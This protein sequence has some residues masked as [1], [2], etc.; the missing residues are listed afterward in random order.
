MVLLPFHVFAAQAVQTFE[1]DNVSQPV[2]MLPDPSTNVISMQLT[3]R[4]GITLDPNGKEGLTSLLGDMMTSGA[5]DYD[6]AALTQIMKDH[7][8]SLSINSRRD[9]TIVSL[10]APARYWDMASALTSDILLHPT[11]DQGEMTR[12]IAAQTASIRSDLADA[13]WRAM[14]LMNG[15]VFKGSPYA[16]PGAG[17]VAS[18]NRLTRKD[19]ANIHQRIF[20]AKPVQAV[21]VGNV[22]QSRARQMLAMF[23]DDL[24]AEPETATPD[25]RVWGTG[26][27][28]YHHAYNV[29]QTTLYYILPGVSPTDPD[30]ATL[31]ILNAWLSDGFGSRLMKALREESGLS[32]GVSGGVSYAAG[33]S[34]W[35]F[36]VRVADA[37]LAK[38]ADILR[39]E[40]ADTATTPIQQSEIDVTAKTLAAQLPMGWTSSPAIAGQLAEAQ[41]N[42]FGPDYLKTWQKRL[43]AVTSE[44]VQQLA[45]LL[46]AGDRNVMIAV[47]RTRPESP[48]WIEETRLPNMD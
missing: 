19:F 41:R 29:P 40:I 4:G 20:G 26:N 39:R 2:W 43:L 8:I 38:A 27:T 22:D 36:S 17:S 7:A 32:Y 25:M 30:Y 28:S 46:L 5:S 31:I 45:K 9:E 16:R 6:A 24:A 33:G 35:V 18:V 21:F 10:T 12:M 42:G 23:V 44:D 48:A 1:T 11:F 13:D 37:E 47:G 15:I 14:R 3:F 34:I